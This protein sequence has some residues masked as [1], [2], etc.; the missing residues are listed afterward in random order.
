MFLCDF[1]NQL[2]Q[3]LNNARCGKHLFTEQQGGVLLLGAHPVG[4]TNLLLSG[5]V[6]ELHSQPPPPPSP[7]PSKAGFDKVEEDRS[8]AFSRS[9]I[10]KS[11]TMCYNVNMETKGSFAVIYHRSVFGEV[12]SWLDRLARTKRYLPF[13]QIYGHLSDKVWGG[14]RARADSCGPCT[15][16]ASHSQ[17][18]F[19]RAILFARPFQT[20]CCAMFL[21]PMRASCSSRQPTARPSSRCTCA[22]TTASFVAAAATFGTLQCLAH[23]AGP[24]IRTVTLYR[25]TMKLEEHH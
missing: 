4:L 5:V 23:R 10:G 21:L 3:L 18:H 16:Y 17:P 22:G 24:M 7:K 6:L 2:W 20:S 11:A 12:L 1:K 9:N 25:Q 13:D 19:P 8:R 15:L 14:S